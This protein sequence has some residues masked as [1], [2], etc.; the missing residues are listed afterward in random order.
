MSL[1]GRSRGGAARVTAQE[2]AARTGPTH[3]ADNTVSAELLDV[4]E[5]YRADVL[6]GRWPRAW[7]GLPV[8]DW[9]GGNGAVA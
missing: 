3:A 2:A 5:P 6:G 7:A 1:S 8:V 4:R 9:R